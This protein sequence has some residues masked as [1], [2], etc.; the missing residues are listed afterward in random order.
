MDESRDLNVEMLELF[1]EFETLIALEHHDKVPKL[2]SKIC[3][4][5]IEFYDE[6]LSESDNDEKAT[7]VATFSTSDF[8]ENL[9]NSIFLQGK[10]A[11]AYA[12]VRE[13]VRVRVSI[14]WR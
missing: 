2:G 10:I 1:K 8:I 6:E 3:T 13:F 11:I 12:E 7:D 5:L 14:V 9:C 4:T